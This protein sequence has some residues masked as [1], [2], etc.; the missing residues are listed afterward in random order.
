M[1][2]HILGAGAQGLLWA[3]ALTE[4]G[5]PASLLLR[6]G[7]QECTRLLTLERA[8]RSLAVAITCAAVGQAESVQRLLLT[9]KAPD[10]E[11]ALLALTPNYP[12]LRLVVL[13]QNGLG[14]EAIARRLLPEQT[15][16][17]LGTSTHG[18]FRRSS[19]HV[20]QAGTGG[21]WLGPGR[22]TLPPAEHAAA[23]ASLQATALQVQ[24]DDAIATRLW[25]KLAVNACINPLTALLNCRNGEL[26]SHPIAQRWLPPL[27]AEAA[28]AAT[29]AGHAIDANGLLQRVTAIAE[30]TAAN[31]NSM[32]QDYSQH[33]RT[34]ID[35]ITGS[36][37]EAAARNGVPVPHHRDLLARVQQRQSSGL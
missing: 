7:S 17:W 16:I 5:Q 21:I 23:L 37:I 24:W 26:L 22:G 6:P 3:A 4:A 36:L 34:E 29:A 1:N 19:Q 12:S 28:A 13:L 31:Y 8:G 33:R 25:H 10:V 20:V 35:F 11:S 30:A 9:V 15:V 18:S 32:Q 14:A 2:W 27:A